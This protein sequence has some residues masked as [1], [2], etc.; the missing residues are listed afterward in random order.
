MRGNY[1]V[2]HKTKLRP[3]HNFGTSRGKLLPTVVN[4]LQYPG[5][6]RSTMHDAGR[7][8]VTDWRHGPTL[9]QRR[10][11]GRLPVQAGHLRERNRAPM[12][13]G[14]AEPVEAASWPV[15]AR[16]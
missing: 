16:V 3:A 11:L 6:G 12:G 10:R 15:R 8:R 5:Q 9:P 13:A 14:L 2:L 1:A 7:R 4:T